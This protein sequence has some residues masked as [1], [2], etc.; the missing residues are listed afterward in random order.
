GSEDAGWTYGPNTQVPGNDGQ[1]LQDADLVVWYEAYMPHAAT[2][3]SALWHSTGI[4]LV[5]NLTDSS[6]PTA[7]TGLNA[8][9]VSSNQV[10]L[11][12]IGS[13]DD[14]A[15]A[16][17]A[18]ERCQGSGCTNFQ[19]VANAAGTS[20]VEAGLSAGVIYRYRVRAR[21]AS[22]NASGPSNVVD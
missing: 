19:L 13:T 2:A 1:S 15:V 22:G 18:I 8:T 17:Y 21:D 3:G 12:W 20:A 14:V 9:A 5:S 6:P 7:P 4:R 16:G 11:S 10:N